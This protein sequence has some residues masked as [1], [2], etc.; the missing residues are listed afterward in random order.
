MLLFRRGVAPE[1]RVAVGE[2]TE[3]VHDVAMLARMDDRVPD[4][5]GELAVDARSE[6]LPNAHGLILPLPILGVLEGHVEEHALNRSQELVESALPGA[7]AARERLGV[8][9][10]GRARAAMDV[11]RELIEDDDQG[12]DATRRLL[13]LFQLTPHRPLVKLPEAFSAL[14]I[15]GG[16][17]LKPDLAALGDRLRVVGDPPEPEIEDI[18]RSD[19]RFPGHRSPVHGVSCKMS[20]S[21]S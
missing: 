11:A 21:C 14:A 4:V 19:R 8:A 1:H 17:R 13:P 20:K 15:K 16:I 10:E 7:Q 12:E 3:A 2:T 18:L 9:G 6:R 5:L